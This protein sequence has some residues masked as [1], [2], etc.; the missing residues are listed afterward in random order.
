MF[1][2]QTRARTV[3]TQL[4]L[5]TTRKGNLTVAEYFGKM[6]SLGDEMAAVTEPPQK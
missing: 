4:A 6:K 2:S 3:N 5:G 1:A